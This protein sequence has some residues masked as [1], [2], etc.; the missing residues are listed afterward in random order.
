MLCFCWV[1]IDNSKDK[2]FYVFYVLY[3][4]LYQANLLSFYV[5]KEV[6]LQTFLFWF[7]VLEYEYEQDMEEA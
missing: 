5:I 2:N 4:L 1:F 3:Y 6:F 7:Q